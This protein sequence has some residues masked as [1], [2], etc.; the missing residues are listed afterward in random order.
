MAMVFCASIRPVFQNTLAIASDGRFITAPGG[1][2]I[3]NQQRVDIG[4][5]G[6]SGDTWDKDEYCAIEEIKLS[7]LLAEPSEPSTEWNSSQL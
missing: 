6:I 5:V 2:L 3:L 4:V 7:A 1:E